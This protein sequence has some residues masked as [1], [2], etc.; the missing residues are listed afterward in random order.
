[1]PL[2]ISVP[3]IWLKEC[4]VRYLF[5]K[6]ETGQQNHNGAQHNVNLYFWILP[7]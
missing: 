6:K 5:K 3:R 2:N 1:M 7:E 4:A